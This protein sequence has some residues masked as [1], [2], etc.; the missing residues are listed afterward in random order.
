VAQDEKRQG[1]KD[2]TPEGLPSAAESWRRNVEILELV[3][4]IRTARRRRVA[5][6]PERD[7]PTRTR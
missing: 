4:R 1:G 6:A 3:D 7:R 2:R 5:D